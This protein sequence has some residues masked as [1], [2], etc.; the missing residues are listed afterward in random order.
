MTAGEGLRQDAGGDGGRGTERKKK[1]HLCSSCFPVMHPAAGEGGA[2]VCVRQRGKR[3]NEEVGNNRPGEEGRRW[4][5]V[6][7]Q[8]KARWRKKID[9]FRMKEANICAPP[10][11]QVF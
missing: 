2:D 1:S 9:P 5:G 6:R 8:R 7:R 10:G 11:V 4:T 3:V